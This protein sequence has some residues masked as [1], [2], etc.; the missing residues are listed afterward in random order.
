MIFEINPN[1]TF[2]DLR[3]RG[4]ARAE[5]R[6]LIAEQLRQAFAAI[7]SGPV[8]RARVR[9]TPEPML[10]RYVQMDRWGGPARLWNRLRLLLRDRQKQG[11]N[12]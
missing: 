2:P 4:D 6:G 3:Q 11:G 9:F 7:D 1:P 5:R 12:V 10:R 8:G